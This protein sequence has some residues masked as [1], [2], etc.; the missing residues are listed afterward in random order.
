M[1]FDFLLAYTA[2][3]IIKIFHLKKFMLVIGN[4]NV[5]KTKGEKVEI[6]S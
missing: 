3:L 6:L 5:E 4:S 2:L 1:M